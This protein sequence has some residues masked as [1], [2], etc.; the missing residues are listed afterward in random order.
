M[1]P[2][3]SRLF[4]RWS[5][6]RNRP[7]LQA[8]A[9]LRQESAGRIAELET[10]VEAL[11]QIVARNAEASAER[12]GQ[13]VEQVQRELRTI[14]DEARGRNRHM[15][16]YLP[17]R[18]YESFDVAFLARI[19]AGLSSA[20]FFNQHLYALPSFPSD[21]AL[22]QHCLSL[23]GADVRL[24]LEFGVFSGRTIR[25]IAGAV[26]PEVPVYGFDSFEGL[27]ETWRSD[28]QQGH[29]SRPELPEVPASVRLVKGWFNETLPGFRDE[30]MG[31]G[32]TNFIHMDC[33]LYSSTR[34]V[35][36][37]LEQHIAPDG[38]IVFDE[39]FNYPGWEQ[40]EIRALNE[41][42]DRTGRRYDFI[43]CVPIHQQ[44]AIRFRPQG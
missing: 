1:H 13:G 40:H 18:R 38:I 16:H 22:I 43:G 26:G 33:D 21:E 14:L 41:F 8:V 35:L 15:D 36:E 11:N 32:Q 31:Q 2:F 37:T 17:G 28:F 19:R 10:R 34:T 6:A 29:F 23:L 7:L 9:Q 5:E 30:V 39:F 44:V 12:L 20:D 3:V 25:V 24:P 27:P 4:R 42:C